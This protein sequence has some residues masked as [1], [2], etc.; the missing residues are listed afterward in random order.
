[1]NLSAEA[2]LALQRAVDFASRNHYEYVT[3][4]IV[5]LMMMDNP[6]FGEA[7]EACGGDPRA[8]NRRLLTYIAKYI[9]KVKD[10]NSA[11]EQWKITKNTETNPRRY[12]YIYI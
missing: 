10:Q 6:Y 1:M 4:E 5:F 9:E 8:L 3:P 2:M 12:I 11:V 7:Y